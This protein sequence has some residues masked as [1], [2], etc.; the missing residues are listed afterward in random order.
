MKKRLL[1]LSCCLALGFCVNPLQ[2]APPGA[3]RAVVQD[4]FHELIQKN[5][6]P[7]CDLAGVILT[8]VNLSGAN[9]EGANLAG[10]KLY[11]ADLSDANLKNANLQGAGLGGAD[12]AGADLTGANL[13]GAILE[14]AYFKGAKTDGMMMTRP[15]GG[16]AEAEAG[17]TVFVAEPSQSKFTP[18]S[19]D[20]VVEGRRDLKGAPAQEQG[21][22][23]AVHE[24]PESDA[25]TG[26]GEV[27]AVV[28]SKSPVPMKNAVVAAPISSPPS[29]PTPPSPSV[30][31]KVPSGEAVVLEE[32]SKRAVPEPALL[33]A[34]EKKVEPGVEQAQEK[35]TPAEVGAAPP[36][37]YATTPQKAAAPESTES[38][39]MV[40]EDSPVHNMIA[41]IEADSVAPTGQGSKPEEKSVESAVPTSLAPQAK[42]QGTDTTDLSAAKEEDVARPEG[43]TVASSASS[44]PQD[45]SEAVESGEQK[46]ISPSPAVDGS[47]GENPVQGV[48]G[49]GLVYT[50]ET[51]E[52]AAVEQQAL[53]ERL[54]DEDRC[55]E[56]DLAGV[57]LS[58]K[59]LKEVDLE[60]AN[61][62]D[63]NLEGVNLSEANLKGVDFSGA[64]LRDA[65]LSGAD[66][67]KAKFAG[68]DLSG[69]DLSEALIDS[70]DFAGAVGLSL[71]DSASAE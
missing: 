52:A 68:A 22:A 23:D 11:L 48:N 6:C 44:Q 3:E 34:D 43:E 28:Q 32:Q 37:A 58:G 51:P 25:G 45:S 13:T 70:T 60:R 38:T 20:V 71:P 16:V 53:V 27:D 66:L 12:L 14:G 31:Q 39:E 26:S 57:N 33:K 8:R 67:Y 5:S 55:V 56:C 46:E 42:E 2:A 9:L 21:K 1:S 41:Q 36:E 29:P 17:E 7:G 62:Q 64:N 4:A 49:T 65:D 30:S 18:Y 24:T 47:Q 35:A 10:A 19:Q 59:R 69:A 63:A 15:Q 50:V 40:A 61:L 54:L